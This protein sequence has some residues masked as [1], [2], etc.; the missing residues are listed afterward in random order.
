MNKFDFD[1][2]DLAIV[3]I[4]LIAICA[5]F[6]IDA[7]GNIVTQALIALGALAVGRKKT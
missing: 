5:T 3:A 4:L 2:K 6:K 1:D 7:P